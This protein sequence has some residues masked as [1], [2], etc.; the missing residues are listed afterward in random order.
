[1]KKLLPNSIINLLR[2]IPY[3]AGINKSIPLVMRVDLTLDQ[4]I[5]ENK[6]LARF[7]DGEFE[8][9][10][11]RS[12]IFEIA[13]TQ[14]SQK[15]SECLDSNIPE[16]IIGLPDIFGSLRNY[17]PKSRNYWRN[18]LLTNRKK[19]TER[20]DLSRVYG[21]SMVTRTFL[22]AEIS[23]EKAHAM[24]NRWKELWRDRKVLMVRGE[25]DIFGY[26]S[27]LFDGAKVIGTVI[28]PSKN[29][30][31]DYDRILKEVQGFERDT[32]ILISL[33]ATATVMAMDLT[34]MGYQAVDIGHLHNDYRHFL[35]K[36]NGLP[37][38]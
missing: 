34:K 9:L 1:M 3:E 8:L 37:P 12:S 18:Y 22:K 31:N 20:I 38:L 10:F 15:L 5:E 19:I 32:L 30:F 4:V 21:N 16:L 25:L 28:C 29:A 7:G 24:F 13:N 33:G 27:D 17:Q 14:L 6:S 35:R 11:G 2:N 36:I 23:D 26:D